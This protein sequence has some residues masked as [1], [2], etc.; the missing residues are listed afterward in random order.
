M[1]K[2]GRCSHAALCAPPCSAGSRR[3]AYVCRNANPLSQDP[4]SGRH[5][6]SESFREKLNS[7]RTLLLRM[8]P[9]SGVFAGCSLITWVE[10]LSGPFLIDL[11][12]ERLHYFINSGDRPTAVLNVRGHSPCCVCQRHS[13]CVRAG[14]ST[15]N[16]SGQFLHKRLIA[17]MGPSGAGKT[18][19]LRVRCL[20]PPVVCS[21]G[22]SSCMC[23]RVCVC[24]RC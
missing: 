5:Q 21:T 12:F 24:G 8:C 18:T 16:V 9:G 17:I 23:A 10:T 3:G 15:Q 6:R 4:D 7:F 2:S 14:L 19:L 1:R 13:H 20:L 22:D 11:G